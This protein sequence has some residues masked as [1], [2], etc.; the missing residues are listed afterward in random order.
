MA[1][2]ESKN[3]VLT[4]KLN[5]IIYELL[6]KTCSDMVYTNETTTLTETLSDITDILATHNDN[7][8]N[9]ANQI[10]ALTGTDERIL[11]DLEDIWNYINVDGDPKSALIQLIDS[12]VEKVEGKGLSEC[13]FTAILKDKLVNDYTKDE[14]VDKFTI[15][16]NKD[17]QQDE[18]IADIYT[19]ID[20]IEGKDPTFIATTDPTDPAIARLSDGAIWFH[21]IAH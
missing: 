21:I 11:A 12:K 2:F 7:F 14:L 13:D 10:A 18:Q 5:G 6:V 8:I 17:A 20:H 9:V 16:A 19:K 1:R 15:I 4:K 3:T